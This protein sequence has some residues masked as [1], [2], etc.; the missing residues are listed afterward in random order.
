MPKI[1]NNPKTKLPPIEQVP[2]ERHHEFPVVHL[3]NF[4]DEPNYGERQTWVFDFEGT[5]KGGDR[6][7]FSWCVRG[8]GR[9]ARKSAQRA[10]RLR[11]GLA[12]MT[13]IRLYHSRQPPT[14]ADIEFIKQ[15]NEA[16]PGQKKAWMQTANSHG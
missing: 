3:V 10:L 4:Y 8:F 2:A 12:G 11:A 1:A 15:F 13:R 9:G 5:F 14:T 7:F 16:L 6:G